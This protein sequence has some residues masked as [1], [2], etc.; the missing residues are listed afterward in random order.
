MHLHSQWQK[1]LKQ[2]WSLKLMGLAAILTCI[3]LILPFFELSLS[4]GLY[5][6]LLLIITLAAMLSRLL[7]QKEFTKDV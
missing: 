2:A 7:V 3:E 5:A 6:I 4:R 1:I